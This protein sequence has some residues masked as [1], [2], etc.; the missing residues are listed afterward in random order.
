MAP[1]AT[2]TTTYVYES[3]SGQNISI[4][5]SS[6]EYDSTYIALDHRGYIYAEQSGNYTF[7]S[8]YVDDMLLFWAGPIAYSGWNGDNYDAWQ[9]FPVTASATYTMELLSGQYFPI[10]LLYVNAE[11]NSDLSITI[12]APDGT[13]IISSNSTGSP[14]IVQSSCDTTSA[15]PYPPFGQES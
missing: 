13:E 5:G 4:Y 3:G 2:G 1:Q 14:Y 7:S 9:Y 6:G 10:R 15:P 11:T 8:T 12:T